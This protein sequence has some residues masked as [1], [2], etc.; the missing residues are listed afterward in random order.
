MSIDIAHLLQAHHNP[1]DNLLP[2]LTHQ[3]SLTDKLQALSGDAE[4][5]V[6]K[7]YWTAPNWW[8]KH[9]LGISE[10]PILHREILMSSHQIPCWYARTI[11]PEHTYQASHRF[12]NRLTQESLGVIIFNEPRIKRVQ[13]VNYQITSQCIEYHW[14]NP[15]LVLKKEEQ[16]W[17]RLSIFNTD[18]M[19]N[20]YLIEILLPGLMRVSA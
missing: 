7:Q 11:V 14:L 4:L 15:F 3:A 12:F 1:P 10:K 13:L 17:A 2:W 19:F 20:F 18:V 6:L 5:V 16:F 9:T 8:D